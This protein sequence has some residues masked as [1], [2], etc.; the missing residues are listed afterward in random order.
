MFD[1][2]KA[3]Q[4]LGAQLEDLRDA[5]ENKR[6]DPQVHKLTPNQRAYAAKELN[7]HIKQLYTIEPHHNIDEVLWNDT[8]HPETIKSFIDDFTC[9][10]ADLYTLYQEAHKTKKLQQHL[11]HLIEQIDAFVFEGIF[12]AICIHVQHNDYTK[13][14]FTVNATALN[15]WLQAYAQTAQ[16]E[17]GHDH[18]KQKAVEVTELLMQTAR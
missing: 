13:D 8:P 4:L 2:Q 9:L 18:A 10:R 17:L 3:F 7:D 11:A 14:F 5:L 16:K 12:S 1:A 6:V 15:G